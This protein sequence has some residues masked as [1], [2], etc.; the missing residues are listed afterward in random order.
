MVVA[1]ALGRVRGGSHRGLG[2]RSPMW[3]SAAIGVRLVAR[4]G[5]TAGFCTSGRMGG[6]LLHEDGKRVAAGLGRGLVAGD[7]LGRGACGYRIM[8]EYPILA[9]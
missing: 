7:G 3:S 1:V 4:R 5:G 9:Q 6:G 2:R 8:Q